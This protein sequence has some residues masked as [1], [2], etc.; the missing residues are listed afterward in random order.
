[1]TDGIETS[2]GGEDNP[3]T[4]TGAFNVVLYPHRSLG[5]RGFVTLMALLCLASFST[6][7]AFML[8][9]AWPVIGFF[10]LDVALVYIVFKLNY[11]A[12]RQYETLDLTA[13]ELVVRRVHPGGKAREWRFEPFWLRA[14]VEQPHTG[15]SRLILS[16][17]GRHV[18]LGGFLPLAE[19]LDLADA[20]TRALEKWRA[21]P[22]R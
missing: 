3:E 8:Q 11:R 21:G 18:S 14:A 16:S 4:D 6:G 2:A 7:I 10:G 13:D 12:G 15:A 17:H 9:G 20:L 1:M 19:R 5:R 22:G